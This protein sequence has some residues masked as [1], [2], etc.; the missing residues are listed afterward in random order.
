METVLYFE[1]LYIFFFLLILRILRYSCVFL[2]WFSVVYTIVF[3]L[4]GLYLLYTNDLSAVGIDYETN[5]DI[6]YSAALLSF[7]SYFFISVIYIISYK[8]FNFKIW[9][10][11][12]KAKKINWFFFLLM[13]IISIITLV[14]LFS[15][16]GGFFNFLSNLDAYRAGDGVGAGFLQYPATMILPAILFFYMAANRDTHL[17]DRMVWLYRGA[18]IVSLIPL[19]L[20]GFR[21]PV[22]IVTLQF[23]FFYNHFVSPIKL[24]SL[25]YVSISS[26]AILLSWGI[27]R[28]SQSTGYELTTFAIVQ[29]AVALV[30][31]RTRGIEALSAI[32]SKPQNI[33][34][35]F[36][37][38]NLIESLTSFVPRAIYSEKPISTTEEITTL[39]FAND[40]FSIGIIREVYGGV[41][42]TFLGH[43]YWAGGIYAVI[44][45]SFLTGFVLAIM[46]KIYR[47]N[48]H[49][50]L[51]ILFCGIF[52]SYIHF[53]IESFQLAINA[54]I[55]NLLMFLFFILF[56]AKR[57]FQ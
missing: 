46:Q 24:K 45:L 31:F 17:S 40:L 51:N 26:F 22:V 47:D 23:L 39:Y 9:K 35:N 18:F 41:S 4:S 37:L 27:A 53:Y 10:F 25:I 32:I 16:F 2:I 28:E 3:P 33:D 55:M 6:Y 21:G 8:I 30:L 57:K 20:L 36:F 5:Q 52:F 56:L 1:L 54:I 15:K 12:V 29:L 48:L 14:L 50:R 43:A 19:I 49:N 42:S 7:L 13:F 11:D 34:Y 44:F 38:P